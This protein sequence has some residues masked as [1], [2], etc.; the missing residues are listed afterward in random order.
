MTLTLLLDLDNTLLGNEM[1]TFLPAYFQGLGRCLAPYVE[2]GKMMQALLKATRKMIENNQPDRTLKEVFDAHFY[3]A[4]GLAYDAVQE[5]LAHFYAH[6]YTHLRPL[7]QLRPDAVAL[8]QTALKRGYRIAVAT[9]PLF[10]ATAIH[11]RVAWAGLPPD[12]IPFAHITTSENAHF[13]KPN[14]AFY[15]EI[16]AHLGWPEEPVLMAGDDLERDIA[17]T[18]RLGMS[19]FWI[20]ENGAP[21]G[22]IPLPPTASGPIGALLPWLDQTGLA[23]PSFNRPDAIAAT[24]RATPAVLSTQLLALPS[25]TWQH[26]PSPGEWNLT[27]IA[28][29]MRDAEESVHLPRLQQII[30]EDNPFLTGVDTDS[31]VET[32][33]YCDQDGPTALRDFVNHRLQ[34]LS[35]LENLTEDVWQR[36][37]RHAI[38]GPTNFQEI[39]HFMAEHDRLHIR[40]IR[41][42]TTSN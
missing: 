39:S 34:T 41:Q 35:L 4:L 31:W 33:N 24:L 36:P 1:D 40:Q 20:H 32:Y 19:N 3:P 7:T 23:V 2:P 18:S 26:K 10:P 9:N 6:E 12:E 17:P 14:P 8:T 37:A 15:A 22:E 16:L 30:R 28:C 27:E 38:F 42:L 13:A 21:N 5:A 11:Q 25:D 29:H